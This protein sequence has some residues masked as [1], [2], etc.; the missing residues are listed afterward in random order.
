MVAMYAKEISQPWRRWLRRS[1]DCLWL[2]I[3]LGLPVFAYLPGR[4]PDPIIKVIWA[5]APLVFLGW[6]VYLLQLPR[7]DRAKPS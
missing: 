6:V 7:D 2:V 4:Y 5:I 3:D 1:A